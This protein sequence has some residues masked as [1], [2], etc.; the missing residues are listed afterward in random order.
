MRSINF[1]DVGVVVNSME[2]LDKL[3][4]TY[5]ALG[6]SFSEGF[7]AHAVE[8]DGNN[9][10]GYY[11]QSVRGDLKTKLDEEYLY[12]AVSK[13]PIIYTMDSLDFA[14]AY[15]LLKSNQTEELIA[16]LDKYCKEYK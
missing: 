8:A 4:M 15:Q 9:L 6:I 11:L 10:V 16:H 2:E 14:V 5:T 12:V 1:S 13:Y 3:Y 7:I